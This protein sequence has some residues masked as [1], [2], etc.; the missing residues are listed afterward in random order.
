MLQRLLPVG[1]VLNSVRM[2]VYDGN[3]TF[4]RQIGTYPLIVG[5]EKKVP[6]KEFYSGRV[7]GHMLRS[8]VGEIV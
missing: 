8:V 2:E 1:T 7:K 3:H 5:I 6:I 4:G